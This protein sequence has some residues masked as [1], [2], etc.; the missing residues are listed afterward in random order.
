[1]EFDTEAKDVQEVDKTDGKEVP[2][3]D[4][5]PELVGFQISLGAGDGRLFLLPL[6][7]A[8]P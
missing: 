5:S 6:Q 8:A 7:K 3:V 2:V 1:V 4:D